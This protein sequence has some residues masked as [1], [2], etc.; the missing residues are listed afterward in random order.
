MNGR[1]VFGTFR[2][3]FES[4]PLNALAALAAAIALATTPI[5]FAVLSRQ[6][7]FQARRGRTLQRPS[8]LTAVVAMMTTMGIPAILLALL[9]KSQYFDKDRYE[10]D[11]N[12]TISVLDQGREFETLRLRESLYKADEAVR[13]EQKRL[14]E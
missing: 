8:F 2:D 3:F 14:A 11:P 1:D 7:W 5:A 13:A 12:R 10:F 9:V 6:S 4:S